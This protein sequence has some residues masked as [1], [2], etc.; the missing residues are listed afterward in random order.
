MSLGLKSFGSQSLHQDS[1][2]VPP[3][4]P[5]RSLTTSSMEGNNLFQFDI[6]LE[7][8]H[9][10]SSNSD[11]IVVHDEVKLEEEDISVE[12]RKKKK[13]KKDKEKEK[14]EKKDKK[15]KDEKKDKKKKLKK[16]KE[17]DIIVTEVNNEAPAAFVTQPTN[18][19]QFQNSFQSKYHMSTSGNDNDRF[20]SF[21]QPQDMST[22]DLQ[23]ISFEHDDAIEDVAEEKREEDQDDHEELQEIV[24]SE[25]AHFESLISKSKSMGDPQCV[26]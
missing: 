7:R 2:G 17:D 13:K 22:E 10:P 14:E 18:E 1:P 20:N 26:E 9:L 25:R 12:K 5:D 19:F 11:I 8:K 15:E 16:L 23:D 24:L 3:K 21:E 4:K 6:A